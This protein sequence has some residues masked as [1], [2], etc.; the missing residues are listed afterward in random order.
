MGGPPGRMGGRGAGWGL[1]ADGGRLEG[2]CWRPGSGGGLGWGAAGAGAGVRGAG[3]G[4][5]AA[6]ERSLASEKT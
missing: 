1:G 4:S 3:A 2:G 5:P 6:T